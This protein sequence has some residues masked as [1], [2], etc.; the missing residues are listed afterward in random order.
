MKPEFVDNRNGNTLVAAL[1]GHLG[2]L[3]QT[4]ARPVELSVA[5]GY[6]NPEGFALLADHLER[7]PKVR[8][9]LGAE[10]TPPP[11]RPRR[12]LGEPKLLH[13][14]ETFHEGWGPGANAIHPTLGDYVTRLRAV[15]EHYAAWAGEPQGA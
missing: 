14:F 11:A 6:F 13:I 7:L 5:S 9:L 12:R 10:P 8:L 3:E 4:Y 1:R 15:L 2:W